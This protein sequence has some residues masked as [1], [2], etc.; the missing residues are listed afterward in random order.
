MGI[1]C[2]TIELIGSQFQLLLKCC[3]LTSRNC[4]EA[5]MRK[6]SNWHG[7]SAHNMMDRFNTSK[8][9]LWQREYE[10]SLFRCIFISEFHITFSASPWPFYMYPILLVTE[11]IS[12][13]SCNQPLFTILYS[14]DKSLRNL[15][16]CPLVDLKILPVFYLATRAISTSLTF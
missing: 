3:A 16:Q 14:L 10:T 15:P 11:V 4:V 1:A 13:A 6:Y 2:N 9:M 7:T 8:E 5:V 12:P